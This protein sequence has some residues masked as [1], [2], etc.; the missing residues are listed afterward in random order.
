MFA[1]ERGF[2]NRKCSVLV[3]AEGCDYMPI[4]MSWC[5]SLEMLLRRLIRVKVPRAV[6]YYIRR[7]SKLCSVGNRFPSTLNR[8]S[9]NRSADVNKPA[10][11]VIA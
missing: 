7:S 11:A 6:Q 5:F 2:E 8:S 10:E 4:R 9:C 3:L 1:F